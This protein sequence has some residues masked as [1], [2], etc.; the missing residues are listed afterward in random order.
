M[1]APN[2]Y[3]LPPILTGV[4][5]VVAL[6]LQFVA[7]ISWSGSAFWIV[8]GVVLLLG[9]IALM[10]W[11]VVTMNGAQANVMPHRAATRLVTHGPFAWSRNPIYVADIL[12]VAGLGL[13]FRNAWMLI[14]AAVLAL[15]LREL[16]TKREEEHMAERF[17]TK[18]HDYSAR[19][20][21]WL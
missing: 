19:V 6:L 10:A 15:L 20:R 17:G 5:A 12:I 11:A 14:G 1:D 2:R 13:A 7:P 9:G 8:L 4:V 18:W 3:P 21:R 16:A